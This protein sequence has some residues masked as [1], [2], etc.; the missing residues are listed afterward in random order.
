VQALKSNTREHAGRLARVSPRLSLSPIRTMIA[1]ERRSLELSGRRA[2]QALSRLVAFQRQRFDG[3]SKLADSL[4]YKSVLKRG[5]A[6]VRDEKG[7]PVHYAADIR[8]WQA[9]TL[10]FGDGDVK[11]REDSP[12]QGK[13]I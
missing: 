6:L 11:V 9:L 13:L 3:V 4:S 10:E 5:F 12:K 1:G 2:A 7:R 8:Q